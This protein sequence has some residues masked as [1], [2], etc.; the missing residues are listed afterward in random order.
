M[1]LER[2][3]LRQQLLLRTLWR[4]DRPGTLA[5]WTR[6]GH[7]FT[8][9]LQAYQ[10]H[11]GALAERALAAAYPTVQQLIGTQAFAAVARGLWHRHPPTLGDVDRWG[12]LL[13]LFLAEA[14]GLADEPYLTD[15][16][17]LEW[18]VHVAA[19][20]AD[21]H[22]APQ[23]LQGLAD[24]DPDHLRLVPREGTAVLPS[25]HPVVSIW[26]AHR[27]SEQEHPDRL[28]P[29]RLA[30]AE[31]RAETALVWRAGL[32]VQVA[33]LQGAEAELCQAVLRG[34]PLGMAVPRL[35]AEGCDDPLDFEAWLCVQLQR[36]W[37][38]GVRVEGRAN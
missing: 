10:A 38:A 19:A 6:N 22:A 32:Q 28:E 33:V 15:V 17:R 2:E 5:G 25:M 3:A 30:L 8:R 36:G 26:Q 4:D 35:Q 23:G 13:P 12:A 14:D 16:A 20:A 9:G 37:L 18:A 21:D 31:R 27:L 24:I 1:S 34:V 7:R 11:A 29:A